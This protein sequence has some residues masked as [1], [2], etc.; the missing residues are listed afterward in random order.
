MLEFIG[1]AVSL[2]IPLVFSGMVLIACIK[3]RLF[4]S[5]D[6]PIDGGRM[7]RGKPLFGRNKT[8]RGILVHFAAAIIACGVLWAIQPYAGWVSP[9]YNCG[10]VLL[11][12][13]FAAAYIVGELLNSFIKRRVG[14]AAGG[15]TKDPLQNRV[16]YF[17]DTADGIIVVG[18]V[19]GFV[20]VVPLGQVLLAVTLAY[21][22]HIAIDGLMRRLG[23]K[24]HQKQHRAKRNA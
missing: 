11:G 24:K 12:S 4:T 23:L 16:Q 17:F 13:V 2:L 9:V 7:W 10:P 19:L 6:V 5:L 22:V 20:F 21:F 8:Y 15:F 3:L 18:L 14:V 1:Q